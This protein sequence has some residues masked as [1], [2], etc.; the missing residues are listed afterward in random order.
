ME[1]F[2]GGGLVDDGFLFAGVFAGL[3]EFGG[4]GGG[5]EG[6]VVVVEGEVGELVL[7]LVAEG[8]NFLGGGAFGAVEAEGEAEE[9]GFDLAL[10]DDFAEAVEGFG[11]GEVD[12]FDGVGSDGEVVGGGKA[13][14]G[15]SVVDG[16]DGVHGERRAKGGDG[17]RVLIL[18]RGGREDFFLRLDRVVLT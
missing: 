11:G 15:V 3:V 18:Y 6:F 8:A 1:D 2:E 12:G 13:D 14:A 7:E 10:G 16:E 5:G 9:E 17:G 4:G